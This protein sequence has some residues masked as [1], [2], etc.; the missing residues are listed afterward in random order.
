M[1]VAGRRR[2][3]LRRGGNRRKRL[4]EGDPDGRVDP[5]L[6]FLQV[7]VP[8]TAQREK[9]DCL[10]VLLIGALKTTNGSNSALATA[11]LT[12]NPAGNHHPHRQQIFCSNHH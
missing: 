9:C 8:V 2:H 3:H 7:T 10:N 6:W 5:R 4:L 12:V 11:G 1:T